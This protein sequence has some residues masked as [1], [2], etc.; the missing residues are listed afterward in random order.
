MTLYGLVLVGGCAFGAGGYVAPTLGL[1]QVPLSPLARMGHALQSEQLAGKH[2][3]WELLERDIEKLRQQWDGPRAGVLEVVV[4]VRGL[5][6]R[7]QPDWEQ[8]AA[9]CQR[10]QWPRCDSG[11]LEEMQRR[12]RP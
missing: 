4:G 6:N 9:A 5:S 7:H 8:A 11:A 12:S 10:L 1:D 2:D 3:D